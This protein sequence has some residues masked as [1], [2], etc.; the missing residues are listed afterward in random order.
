MV[1]NWDLERMYREYNKKYFRNRLPKDMVVEF[2]RL[3]DCHGVTHCHKN[4]P[5]FI[6]IDWP[7]R[8]TLSHSAMTL[9]HEMVHVE[10][11]KWL[12]GPKF[13]RRMLQLAK[14]GAFK[15]WW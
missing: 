14:A 12:H 7:L 10:H 5:L 4:R 1:T 11:P 13:H 6:Q 9:L 3:P 15:N 2:A 8:G